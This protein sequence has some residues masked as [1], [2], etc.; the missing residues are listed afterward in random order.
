MSLN[1]SI[2]LPLLKLLSG[3]ASHID[4]R[5]EFCL[6]GLERAGRRLREEMR[7]R[8]RDTILRAMMMA[9]HFLNTEQGENNHDEQR[10][11]E[12]AIEMPMQRKN[13]VK[14]TEGLTNRWEGG[15][16][17]KEDSAGRAG[18]S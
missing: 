4:I 3:T 12:R 6:C 14:S 16:E 9:A 15:N 2:I 5:F 10:K 13:Q 1:Y 17:C 8:D 11:E 7:T 18:V